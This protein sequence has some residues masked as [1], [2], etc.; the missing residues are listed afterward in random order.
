MLFNRQSSILTPWIISPDKNRSG[1]FI[2]VFTHDRR[3]FT[4]AMEEAHENN[5]SSKLVNGCS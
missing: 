1:G 2:P 4:L 5:L 3:L